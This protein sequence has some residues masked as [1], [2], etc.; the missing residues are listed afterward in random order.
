MEQMDGVRIRQNSPLAKLAA[1]KLGVDSVALT[2]GRTIHLHNTGKQEFLSDARWVRHELAHIGQ[3]RRYGFFRF[4]V[5]Y[6]AE[7]LRRGYYHN[8]FEV[9]ARKAEELR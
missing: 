9:E 4:I 2:L 8:R 6:L 7:S 1:I 3:F 5:L